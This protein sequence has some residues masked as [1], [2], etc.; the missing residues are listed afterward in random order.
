MNAF[1][2]CAGYGTRLHPLTESTP[3]CLVEISGEPLLS[4]WLRILDVYQIETI[5]INTHHLAGKIANYIKNVN[6]KKSWPWLH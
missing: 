2:L 6:S 3:K 5:L 4:Y 1:L